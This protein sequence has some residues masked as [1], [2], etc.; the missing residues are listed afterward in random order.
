MNQPFIP[1]TTN[2]DEAPAYWF[3]DC[4]W[5]I[6]ST[7]KETNGQYSLIEQWMPEGSGP[8]PHVHNIEEIFFM[9]EGEMT[10]HIGEGENEK[11]LIIGPG[12]VGNV[13]RNTV[14][15]FRTTKGP[16][17]VLNFYTPA[18]FELALA[19]IAAPAEARTLP[20]KG[21]DKQ[22]GAQMGQFLNNYWSSQTN[23]PWAIQ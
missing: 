22:T 11:I 15:W 5:I 18:G 13:P 14:H 19:G 12:C 8:P 2:G 20:P 16:C 1:F 6:H 7:A 23:V 3:L 17:R 4:L 21:Y 10:V 9:I